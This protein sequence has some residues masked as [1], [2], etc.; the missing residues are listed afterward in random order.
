MRAKHGDRKSN[1]RSS[2]MNMK[3]PMQMT[4]LSSML[5]GTN[6][7]STMMAGLGGL[8]GGM[9]GLPQMGEHSIPLQSSLTH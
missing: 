1:R 6:P 7:Y 2:D 4:G 8:G 3:P 5:G 9:P